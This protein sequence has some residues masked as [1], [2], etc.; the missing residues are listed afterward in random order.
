MELR[1]K[2]DRGVAIKVYVIQSTIELDEMSLDEFRSVGHLI[3]FANH[4][5]LNIK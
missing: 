1:S 2:H 5:S 4:E 3:G